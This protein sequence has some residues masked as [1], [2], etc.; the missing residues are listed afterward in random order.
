MTVATTTK[1]QEQVRPSA[2]GKLI[3]CKGLNKDDGDH[4]VTTQVTSKAE[5][6]RRLVWE[7]R[8]ND[9]DIPSMDVILSVR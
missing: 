9:K 2:E 4:Q 3:V 1:A 7:Y 5:N 6:K 8:E